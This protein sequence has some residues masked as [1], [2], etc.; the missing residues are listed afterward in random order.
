MEGNKKISIIVPIYNCEK[1]LC[2]CLDSIKAQIYADFEAIL[3]DDGSSD[4][5]A[6]ICKEY[7]NKD[8]RF[9]YIFK[10]NGGV[11]SARNLGLDRATGD[12][13]AFVDGD[14]EILPDFLSSL[15]KIIEETGAD[16]SII[17]PIIRINEKDVPYKDEEQILIYSPV[18]AIKE[19]LR[20]VIFAGHLWNKL[21]KASLFEGVRLREDLAICED[22]VAV[23]ETFAKTTKVAFAN[24]HKYIYYTNET[25]AINATFKES[26]L[27]YIT[28][29][30]YLVE[31]TQ[32]DFPEIKPYALSTLVNAYID[33]TNKLYFAKKLTKET[34]RLH[35][36][37]LKEIASRQ[38]LRLMP[39][40]KRII[41]GAI[42]GPK[43]YYALVIRTFNFMKKII[44][45]LTNK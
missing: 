1:Y 10:E 30:E 40:Y 29:G 7:A 17:S 42:K 6:E 37:R 28:A 14:D 24:L 8:E 38:V 23:Y 13:L 2:R 35:K 21:F 45:F 44:Y 43:W 27:S 11:S 5:S 31:R 25:S 39:R 12:Y 15:A 18:D 20:G 33:V 19:T 22:L 32:S 4:K 34:H 36:A 9:I 16:V 3:V 41:V 26:F